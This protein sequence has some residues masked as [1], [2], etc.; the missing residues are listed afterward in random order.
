M[1][2]SLLIILIVI[3]LSSTFIEAT[4]ISGPPCL[5]LEKEEDFYKNVV[6]NFSESNIIPSWKISNILIHNCSFNKRVFV[7]VYYLYDFPKSTLDLNYKLNNFGSPHSYGVKI[8]YQIVNDKIINKEEIE[9]IKFKFNIF[10]EQIKKFESDPTVKAFLN[11][12]SAKE[13]SLEWDSLDIKNPSQLFKAA[14]NSDYNGDY[15]RYDLNTGKIYPFVL[16]TPQLLEKKELFLSNIFN[17]PKIIEFKDNVGIGEIVYTRGNL[18]LFEARDCIYCN[19]KLIITPSSGTIVYYMLD[20]NFPW[21]NFPEIAQVKSLVSN[22]LIPLKE[23]NCNSYSKQSLFFDSLENNNGWKVYFELNCIKEK[24]EYNKL[25]G[26]NFYKNGNYDNYQVILNGEPT[27]FTTVEENLDWIIL[28]IVSFLV[29][30][31]I[32]FVFIFLAKK[33]K[34]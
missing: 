20:Y 14:K 25:I 15:I 19:N 6:L 28:L 21:N 3:S 24:S 1:R 8:D 11:A 13:V 26:F 10:P 17:N 12:T 22:K 4:K 2:F 34:A 32:I 9:Q 18:Q 7:S 27:I 23:P 5:P 31:S 29:I 16:I 30:I 33:R